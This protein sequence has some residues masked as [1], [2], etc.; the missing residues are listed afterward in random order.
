MKR[1]FSAF[2]VA[3]LA[4]YFSGCSSCPPPAH[5]PFSGV[6][7]VNM[8][9]AAF[10]SETRQDSEPF[11]AVDFSNPAR[12]VGTAFTPNPFGTSGNAP[13]YVS[14]NNGDSWFLNFTVPSF[15][16]FGTSDI[17]VAGTHSPLR[18]YSGILKVPGSLLMNVLNS[19]DFAGGST[20]S[21]LRSRSQIDQPFIQAATI[22]NTERIYVGNND[23]NVTDGKTATV[24]VSLD[25][26]A[27]FRAVR[28]EPRSTGSAGQNGPSIR[29]AVANDGTVYVAYFGWRSFISSTAFG[30][31]VVVRDDNGA[32]GATSFR[33][34]V[35][36]SD[37]LPGRIVAQNVRI[38]WSN[39]PTLGNERIG[40]TL[41][42]A[43]QRT[44]SNI[45]YVCWAD[46]EGST[47]TLHVRRSTDRG[48][49]WSADVRTVANATCGAVAVAD[50]GTAGFLYQH[51]TS[52]SL[53]PFCNGR[54]ET[55]LEQSTN[56]FATFDNILLANVPADDP[57]PVFLPYIGDYNFL[58]AV[59][60]EFRGVFS[61]NNFPDRDNFPNGVTY[62]RNVDFANKRL[63][64][65]SGG[66]VRVSIDPF[67]FSVPV[68]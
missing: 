7:L 3:L 55:R 15:G 17:T 61:A 49:T 6:K 65:N 11:L 5:T 23:F 54:W 1:V 28:I 64:D 57:D 47:Y 13:I 2:L 21:L 63:L 4:A 43:V 50:N 46:G 18:L 27:T 12:M 66:T 41:S 52:T 32:A 9:P 60:N 34:L 35:E 22:A 37:N 31:I 68:R 58:V 20:L 51:V 48:Q 25:G 10:S 19:N 45:V 59:G 30:D 24:D 62:Q 36:P 29:P 33:D 40:S 42:I 44:N 14:T 26:G 56:G 16:E 67:Y 39:A 53:I 8:V 38:P